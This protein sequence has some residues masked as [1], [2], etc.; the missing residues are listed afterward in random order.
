MPNAAD[1]SEKLAN[2][3]LPCLTDPFPIISYCFGGV[4][5]LGAIEILPGAPFHSQSTASSLHFV[6]KATSKTGLAC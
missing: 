2:G 5:R 3:G 6:V 1:A 4:S